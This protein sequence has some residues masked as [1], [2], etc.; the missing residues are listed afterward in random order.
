MITGGNLQQRIDELRESF[1]LSVA[2]PIETEAR[3]FTEYI[4]FKLGHETFAWPTSYI[5]E[6]LLN[7]RIIP[8][9]G[10]MENLYGVVNYKNQVLPVINLHN[11]LGLAVMEKI[12]TN[13]LL[14][15]TGSQ[16]KIAILIDCLKSV[17]NV[18][19]DDIKPKPISLDK[20]A[21]KLVMGEFYNHEGMITLLKPDSLIL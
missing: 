10:R 8:I 13:I 12:E 16:M 5:K 17:L 19:E 14:I 2:R 4:A 7:Q 11:F 6:M 18:G 1:D 3:I 15:T 20:D 9:P 21:E